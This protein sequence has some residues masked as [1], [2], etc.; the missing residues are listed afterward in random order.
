MTNPLLER[1]LPAELAECAQL[2]EY[3]GK[4][5]ELERLSGIVEADLASIRAAD[6][7]RNWRAAAV[8]ARLEFDWSDARRELAVVRGTVLSQLY[9]VCQRCLEA[10]VMPVETSL[11]L[12]FAPPGTASDEM[13]EVVDFEAWELEEE[14]VRLL[15][16]VEESLIMALPLAPMHE[17]DETCGALA[18]SATDER[19]DTV[20]PF[21]DLKSQMEKPNE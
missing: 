9:A 12:I 8:E 10:F 1:V 5:G 21:A 2:I 7:P 11:S 16:I 6:R 20:R 3:K 17:Y 4:V 19:P 14:T 15:D 18:E 13:P